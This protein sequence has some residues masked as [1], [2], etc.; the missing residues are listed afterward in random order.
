MGRATE[1]ARVGVQRLGSNEVDCVLIAVA[2]AGSLLASKTGC[3]DG[4]VVHVVGEEH[5]VMK[6]QEQAGAGLYPV[7]KM[8]A[9]AAASCAAGT[10]V[11]GGGRCAAAARRRDGG[12]REQCSCCGCAC[13]AQKQPALFSP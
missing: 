3:F 4:S 12:G 8:A 9:A 6:K 7:Q 2:C 10:A 13:S 11:T 1:H 5:F